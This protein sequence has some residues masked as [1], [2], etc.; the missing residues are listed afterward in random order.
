MCFPVHSRCSGLRL[1]LS[2]EPRNAKR[3]GLQP[4]PSLSR[5]TWPST[6]YCGC[7]ITVILSPAAPS[8]K[9]T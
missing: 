2:V 7:F 3:Q 1:S 9:A 4:L 8:L 5:L 6:S